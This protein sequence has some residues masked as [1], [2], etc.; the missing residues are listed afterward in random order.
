MI[1]VYKTLSEACEAVVP[2]ETIRQIKSGEFAVF[3]KDEVR[4][5][6]IGTIMPG[7]VAIQLDYGEWI[8]SKPPLIKYNVKHEVLWSGQPKPKPDVRSL[9]LD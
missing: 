9:D 3:N 6:T 2:P 5:S 4:F 8:F 7:E 1:K